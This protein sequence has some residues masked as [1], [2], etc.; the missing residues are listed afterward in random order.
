MP[1][2]SRIG[3][4]IAGASEIPTHIEVAAA[5]VEAAGVEAAVAGVTALVLDVGFALI[6]GLPGLIVG[7]GLRRG[8]VTGPEQ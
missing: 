1:G 3:Q 6:L 7:I 4:A 2:D 8:G 5:G